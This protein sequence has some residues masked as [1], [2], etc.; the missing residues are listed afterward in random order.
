MKSVGPLIKLSLMT[1]LHF[2][3]TRLLALV[4]FP[5]ASTSVLMAWVRSSYFVLIKPYLEGSTILI[6]LLKGPS[7]SPRNLIL[8]TLEGISGRTSPVDSVQL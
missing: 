8:M 5:T 6:V 7:L 1:S 2:E 4:G 3:K